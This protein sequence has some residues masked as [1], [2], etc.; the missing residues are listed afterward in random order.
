MADLPPS[1][2]WSARWI[3]GEVPQMRREGGDLFDGRVA[4]RAA[5]CCLR[6]T[7]TI[8]SV[9][10]RAPAR[11]TADSRYVLWVNGREIAR[12]P[13]RSNPRRLH[14]DE[15][16][17]APHLRA[18]R[19]AI[20]ALVRYFGAANPIWMPAP[21]GFQ[22]GAGSFLFEAMIGG[23]T[24]ASDTHWKAR[25]GAGFA[26]L[27]GRGVAG[28]PIELC[29]AREHAPD[30]HLPD[31]DDRDWSDAVALAANAVGFDGRHEPPS[32]PYG[33]LLPRPMPFLAASAPRDAVIFRAAELAGRGE[34]PSADPVDQAVADLA[35]AG[36]LA[37]ASLPLALRQGEGAQ[38][39]CADFGEV[40]AGTVVLELDAPAGTQVDVAASEFADAGG[41]PRF[42]GERGGFRYVA[43]GVADRFE[44]FG[45]H[46]L[47]HLALA[48]RGPGPATLR[49]VAVVERSAPRPAGASFECSDPLLNRIFAVGRRTVDLCSHDAYVDCP[50]REQRGWTGDFVVHQMVDFATN[51]DW[52]LARWNVEMTASPRPDGML[53]MAAGGDVEHGDTAFIPDWALHWV[54]ALWNLWR[55]TGDREAIGRLLPVAERVL[56]WFEPFRD[57]SGL[58]TDVTGW[59]II[60]WA[61]VS[62]RGQ[63]TALNAL[64]ARGLRDFAEIAEWMGDA[65]R[66]AWARRRHAE[67]SRAFDRFWDAERG[68]YVDH[69]L[70]GAPQRPA[71]QHAQAAAL[72]AGLVPAERVPRVADAM[73]DRARL[74]DAVWWVAKGDARHPGPGED[75]VGGPYLVLGPPAPWWDVE[76]QLVRAQPFFR[77]VVHDALA[78]AGREDRIGAACRDWA[79]L[80]A[81]CETSW[82][83]TW[84]FGTVSHG[85]CSTPTR[86]LV[87]RTL[88]VTPAEPGFATARIA[89]R[90][91]DLAWAR[92]TVPTPFGP[93]TVEATTEGVAVESPV[94]FLLDR[95]DTPATHHPAGRVSLN[96]DL[97]RGQTPS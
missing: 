93:L 40:V 22:L 37:G 85:W 58:A 7:V 81:R 56:R 88:G 75:R 4:R 52:S 73:M 51:P 10:S 50:T 17:L 42:D 31:F 27:P 80:F 36:A 89:P 2:P 18:G 53:P 9:P 45:V 65:G 35:A 8:A 83:E 57:A 29:D 6:R 63:C 13:V 43:R 33:P 68:I 60:D 21:A 90:L 55:Y 5:W 96:A 87:V 69:A 86:D 92:G 64:W 30:W 26:E 48:V 47:R 19:N 20:A 97:R 54:R 67:V 70:A 23:E 76:R 62:T 38:I 12:G 84:T 49:R 14:F 3:W 82:S 11:V 44:T 34:A 95:G 46:G 41:K 39:V 32:Q 15:V 25:S 91:G 16:D 77:Y 24:I 61:S 28:L 66:A 71:S 74:V 78:A 94:P 72:A 79:E 1:R 59:V